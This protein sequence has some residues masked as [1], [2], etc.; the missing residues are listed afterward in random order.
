MPVSRLAH[1]AGR[2]IARALA[3]LPASVN[4]QESVASPWIWASPSL[5]GLESTVCEPHDDIEQTAIIAPAFCPSLSVP[6]RQQLG[7]AFAEAMRLSFPQV[8]EHFAEHVA[9]GVGQTQRLKGSLAASLRLSRATLAVVG[10]PIGVEVFVPITLTLDITNM[11]NGEVVFTRTRTEIA[12]GTRDAA[13]VEQTLARE[14]PGL[15]TRAMQNLVESAAPAFVPSS[16]RATVVGVVTVAGDG[17]AWVINQG[18]NIGLRQNDAIGDDGRIVA[19]GPDHAIVRPALE[20]YR[21]GQVLTR[22]R[23]APAETLARPSLLA[24][25]DM[26]PADFSPAFVRQTFEDAVGG[27]GAF[28]PVPVNPAYAHLR[29]AVLSDAKSTTDDLAR[30]MPDYVALLRVAVL[31]PA[32]YPSNL[33]GVEIDHFEAYASAIVVDRTGRVV[34]AWEGRNAVDDRVNAGVHFPADK[35]REAVLRNALIDLATKLATFRPQPLSLPVVRKNDALFADDPT[36][37]I[38]MQTMFEVMRPAGRFPGITGEV[39]VPVGQVTARSETAGGVILSDASVTPLVLRGK[40]TVTLENSGLPSRSRSA[41]A[42]CQDASGRPVFDSRGAVK[43]LTWPAI[44]EAAFARNVSGAIFVNSMADRL[45]PYSASFNSWDH[46]PAA[47]PRASDLC[48]VPQIMIE[49]AAGSWNIAVGYG[50]RRQGVKA[51]AAALSQTLKP[52]VLPATASP[53]SRQAMAEADLTHAVSS[54]AQQ[55]AAQVKPTL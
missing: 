11:N 23:V 40:E 28:A 33:P 31:D 46:F 34:G 39:M 13:D 7:Q 12:S 24:V 1:G 2:S 27:T 42:Q 41:I 5:F 8:E 36:G 10:K 53:H 25:V 6:F 15:V 35:R 55:V 4:A 17:K 54:L 19:V 45:K 37:A 29:R 14:V 21:T 47:A 51:G 43:L 50:L 44:A 18:R 38:Q 48:F 20:T 30:P 49:P 3:L 26:A 32:T 16:Q 52:T 9:A 22:M